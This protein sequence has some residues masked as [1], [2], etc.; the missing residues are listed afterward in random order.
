[1]ARGLFK[2]SHNF[3]IV[4]DI[5]TILLM[6]D[7]IR[8]SATPKPTS[9]PPVPKASAAKIKIT[10]ES[11]GDNDQ[12]K[13]LMDSSTKK[14][15]EPEESIDL[16][17]SDEAINAAAGVD[18]ETAADAA[19]NKG[20]KPKK[21]RR[22]IKAWFMGLTKK[23]KI[24]FIS[25]VVLL[26]L[27]L[28]GGGYWYYQNSHKK[29]VAIT[30][31]TV[32]V[33]VPTTVASPLTGVQV[34]PE[35]AKRSVTGVMIENSPDAR[36]QSALNQAGIVFE[37][38]AE[39]GIT[40]FLALYQEQT[41][42]YIGPVRS[43][44]PYYLDWLLPFDASYAHV[45]GSPDGLAQITDLHVK[46]LNQFY[47][48]NSYQRI[49]ARAAPHN[50][51][52]SA[53]QLTSLEQSKGFDK[54]TFTSWP[55]KADSPA[56]TPTT[57]SIDLRI[58][59]PLYNVHYDYDKLAN[60]YKRFE[61][62]QPHTDERSGAQITPKIA[63]ALVMPSAIASDGTHTAYTTTG[64]G[65]MYVFQDGTVTQ[66]TWTKASRTGQFVFTKSDG[67]S[68]K[69]NPGKSWVTMVGSTSDVTYK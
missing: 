14:P 60:S 37:A 56:V 28:A 48:G 43:A 61:G 33:V 50:V 54:S 62:G 3:L 51:Y 36:P 40:R 45:G 63:I 42:D 53:A 47:N 2:Q 27:A 41:P 69:L 64:S 10:S 21:H 52:T 12:P 4:Q 16:S 9:A 8:P 58:S 23:K 55:R 38:V 1:M 32:K 59:G 24:L 13:E 17:E 57:T 29:P 18:T 67:S 49:A 6:I 22:S 34:S 65:T 35:L 44:R 11:D 7:D 30:K 25:A 26:I 68:L 31:A 15:I 5:A 66:G 20:K 46:D 39:G 19:A